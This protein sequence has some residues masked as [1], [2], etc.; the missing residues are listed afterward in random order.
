MIDTRLKPYWSV[1]HKARHGPDQKEWLAFISLKCEQE[2]NTLLRNLY[3]KLNKELN[4][5]NAENYQG[6]A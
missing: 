4:H 5:D 3:L 2:P 6:A 1:A